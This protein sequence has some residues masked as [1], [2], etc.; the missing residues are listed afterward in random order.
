V[1]GRELLSEP[2]EAVPVQSGML[3][4]SL[5]LTANQSGSGVINK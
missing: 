3:R 1:P 4:R 5:Q 2:V